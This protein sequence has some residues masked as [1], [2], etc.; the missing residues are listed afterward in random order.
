MKPTTLVLALLVI[1]TLAGCVSQSQVQTL[2]TLGTTQELWLGVRDVSAR[3]SFEGQAHS[4][5]FQVMYCNAKGKVPKCQI[6]ATPGVKVGAGKAQPRQAPRRSQS[7]F[8]I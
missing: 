4:D 2:T 6:V 5:V 1:C 8:G 3:S 7:G